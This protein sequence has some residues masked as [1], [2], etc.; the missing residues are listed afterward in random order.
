MTKFGVN[1]T[2]D[3][4][5]NTSRKILCVFDP[6]SH[7]KSSKTAINQNLKDWRTMK[8]SFLLGTNPERTMT[9]ENIEF[10]YRI[11]AKSL[12]NPGKRKKTEVSRM[13][14]LEARN[15]YACEL[16]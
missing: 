10:P 12:V 8:I 11:M 16:G 7:P 6:R 2:V 3:G 15:N 14:G 5:L 9:K 13:N 4:R 1:N